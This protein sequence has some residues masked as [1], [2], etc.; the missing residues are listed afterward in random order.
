[1]VDAISSGQMVHPARTARL[2]GGG[3]QC[4][5]SSNGH[6]ANGVK[7]QIQQP[8]IMYVLVPS[9]SSGAAASAD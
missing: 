4:R 9:S 5:R 7:L 6:P 2:S 1:M 8:Y 3:R